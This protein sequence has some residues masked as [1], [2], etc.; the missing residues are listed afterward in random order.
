MRA[1]YVVVWVIAGLGFAQA[2]WGD[3]LEAPSKIASV[4]VFPDRALVTRRADVTLT[5]GGHTVRFAPLPGTIEEGSISATGQGAAQVTLFGAKLITLQLEASESPRI[6]ALEEQIKQLDDRSWQLQRAKGILRQEQEFLDSIQVATSEQIGKE[7]ITKQPSVADVA[8]LLEFLDQQW[9]SIAQKDQQADIQL[10]ELAEQRDRLERELAALRGQ[11]TRQQRAI[12]VDLEAQTAGRF[13]MEVS[14]RLPGATWQPL[15]EARAGSQANEV[16]VTAYGLIRQRTGEDWEDV[17][18]TLST[19]RPAI[20]GRMPELQPWWLRK[21][22]PMIPWRLGS[23]EGEPDKNKTLDSRNDFPAKAQALAQADGSE[24]FTA[25]LAKATVETRGPAVTWTLP[26]SET[27][28]SDWQPRKAAIAQY[29]FPARLA[30]ETTPRLSPYAYL[31]AKVTNTSEVV[32]LPGDVQVFLDG[33]FVSA[34]AIDLVGPGETFDLFLGVDERIRVERKA[35]KA[36]VDVSVLP[37][38]HGRMKTI[39]YEYLT[40]IENFRDAAA[41]VTLIDQVPISQHDE[42][43]IEQIEWTP[44]PTVADDEKPGV[45]RWE[46]TIPAG[47]KQTVTLA[48]RVRHPVDFLVEGL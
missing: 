2:S 30:Y 5:Q 1:S 44:K 45:Y 16:Q 29:A 43:K 38:L 40:T 12:A 25:T 13:T 33:A 3:T 23:L 28:A 31:R 10:R 24:A 37:G 8:S 4:V 27:I 26:K 48:Y 20:G 36:K 9:G 11:T 15:Y 17:K 21:A 6:K 39:D 46:L 42:I 18:L 35:L 47:G 41:S 34:S 19:A 7:I 22:E 32:W 14:Y